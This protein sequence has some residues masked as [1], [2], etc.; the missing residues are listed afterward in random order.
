[1]EILVAEDDIDA[2]GMYK[3]ALE[4]GGHKVTTTFDGRE[5]LDTYQEALARLR[6]TGK[7]ASDDHPY[8]AVILDY[9]IPIVDGL[10][11]ARK[12]LTLDPNQR[13][14]FASAYTRETLVNSVRD[15]RQVVELIQKPFEPEVLVKVIED[16]SVAGKLKEL[17]AQVKAMSNDDR[18][19]H[20]GCLLR[21]LENMQRKES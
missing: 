5:C 9:K 21:Q 4:S 13:I 20:I 2:A 10:Q 14:I 17:N 18:E 6:A 1:V 19:N 12:M 8:D 11:V 7:K 16:T 3:A 15:L